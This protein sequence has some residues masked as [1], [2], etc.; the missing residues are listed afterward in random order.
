MT[1]HIAA[2][3]PYYN[4]RCNEVTIENLLR[5]N[6]VEELLFEADKNKGY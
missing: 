3:S 5:F 4:D 2:R 6:R 1:P